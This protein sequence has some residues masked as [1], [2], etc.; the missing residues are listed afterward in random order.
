M[1]GVVRRPCCRQLLQW[2]KA[3]MGWGGTRIASCF[4]DRPSSRRAYPRPRDNAVLLVVAVVAVVVVA[5]A[6]LGAGGEGAEEI[7][8]RR[9]RG[10]RGGSTAGRC[11][12]NGEKRLRTVG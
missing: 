5:A 4:D 10:G 8:G 9:A 6:G 1:V 7:M 2:L 3:G 12:W 11:A